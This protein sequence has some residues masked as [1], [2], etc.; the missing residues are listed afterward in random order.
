[1]KFLKY[2]EVNGDQ[3][4]AGDEVQ[5]EEKATGGGSGQSNGRRKLSQRTPRPSREMPNQRSPNRPPPPPMVSPVRRS[6]EP[7]RARYPNGAPYVQDMNAQ[8]RRL[9]GYPSI[10]SDATY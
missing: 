3:D 4:K 1:M 2:E 9:T 5:D 10:A 7:A 6:F 8:N